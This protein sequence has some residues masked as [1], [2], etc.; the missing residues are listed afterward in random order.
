M[1]NFWSTGK[2]GVIYSMISVDNFYWVLYENLLKPVGLDAWYYYPWGTKDNFSAY[3]YD[4][5]GQKPLHHVLFH[6]D[7][8]PLWST[9]LGNGYLNGPV[10][11]IA[12]STKLCKILAN[13]EHSAI[14]NEICCDRQMEDWYFFYH[15][16]V[17]LDWFR[18]GQYIDI[19]RVP[20][21]PFSSLS[22]IVNHQRAYRMVLTAELI[23]RGLT[24]F[25][26]VSFH[27]T[28]EMC[29][30]ELDDPYTKLSESDKST[31][32]KYLLN[33]HLPMYI[34]TDQS[35]GNLSS[36]FG[37]NELRMWQRSLLHV[38]NETVFYEPKQHLTEKIFKPIVAG[39]PFV[40][41]SAPG[42]LAYLKSY[43]F[44]TFDKWIDESYD[45]ETDSTKRL[46][47]IAEEV[48]KIALLTPP[49]LKDMYQDMYL[50]LQHNKSHLFGNFKTIIVD[51]LISNFDRCLKTWNSR[52]QD[53]Q[54]PMHLNHAKANQKILGI[55]I[56]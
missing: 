9:D 44:K 40:L 56:F 39:R 51:E 45:N 23:A 41:V 54:L 21:K 30:A 35:H 12:S 25:G 11:G 33:R 1:G 37:H 49:Q 2:N 20:T 13:S 3:E 24:D 31:V 15:G 28:P 48:S 4:V 34:D 53:Q 10:G 55:K 36:H 19:D 22:H 42:N 43:G 38:V 14:K 29:R 27:G 17:A 47:M 5:L 46:Q 8:E 32:E 52:S 6:F 50:T 18:D 7:Q 16:F 26:D